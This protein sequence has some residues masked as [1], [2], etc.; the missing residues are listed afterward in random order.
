MIKT[1]EL[2]KETPP[3]GGDVL[4]VVIEGKFKYKNG[5]LKIATGSGIRIIEVKKV[6]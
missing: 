1:F 3:S 5:V 6:N 4:R 2:K